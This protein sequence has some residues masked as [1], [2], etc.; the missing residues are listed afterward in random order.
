V[1]LSGDGENLAI[2]AEKNDVNSNN[3]EGAAYMYKAVGAS[4]QFQPLSQNPVAPVNEANV[5]FSRGL[6][7]S[8]D[9]RVLCAGAPYVASGSGQGYVYTY[10]G[11]K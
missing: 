6:A 1:E 3:N 2:S 9:A 7:L 5:Y 8:S 11:T 4:K 10:L